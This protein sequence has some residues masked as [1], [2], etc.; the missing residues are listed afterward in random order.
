MSTIAQGNVP[1]FSTSNNWIGKPGLK[2]KSESAASLK[3]R[4]EKYSQRVQADAMAQKKD[5]WYQDKTGKKRC[6][7]MAHLRKLHK[8]FRKLDADGSGDIDM[9]EIEDYISRTYSTDSP[10]LTLATVFE[11]PTEK[12]ASTLAKIEELAKNQTPITVEK[13][14][15]LA[16]PLAP[17]RAVLLMTQAVLDEWEAQKPPSRHQE[18]VVE[19]KSK[20]LKKQ[21]AWVNSMWSRWDADGSGELDA[22]ELK[23]V[24]QDIGASVEESDKYFREIDI[25]GSGFISKEEFLEWWL[26]KD[27]ITVE[28]MLRL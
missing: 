13:F 21:T 20:H 1:R 9:E 11:L 5:I 10:A 19:S 8:F 15:E 4:K 24:L 2:D 26:E 22:K 28:D 27:A 17:T 12:L 16:H 6:T 14:L 23:S 7:T 25:D 18:E 3:K